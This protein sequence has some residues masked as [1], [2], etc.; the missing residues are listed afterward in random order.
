MYRFAII[1]GGLTA[2]SMVCQLVDIMRTKRKQRRNRLTDVHLDVF[3]K[4][5][6]I[7]PG[8]P[9]HARFVM[10]YHITNMCAEEMTV[11]ISHPGDF[12]S[13]I[14]EN[15]GS[16]QKMCSERALFLP[17]DD[18][19]DASCHHFPRAIMGE[20][21]KDRMNDAVH[22]ADDSG[23]R[24]ALHAGS[25]VVDLVESD[26]RT[27]FVVK[28]ESGSLVRFG[29]YDGALL[30]TGHWTERSRRKNYFSS[31]WPAGELLQKIP[32]G[33]KVGVIGSS[34]SAVEV[35]L[36]LSSDGRFVRQQDGSLAYQ[37]SVS[38]RNITLYSRRGLLPRV[39]GRIGA[40][41]NRYLTCK[42]LRE[43]I[44]A[45]PSGVKLS[46]VFDLLDRELAEVY[47][48]SIDWQHVVNPAK[49][50]L[51]R[52]EDDLSRARNGDG[53]DGELLWQTVLVEIFPVARELYLHLEQSDRARFDHEFNTLF[54]LH[55]AT[56]PAINAE[57]LRALIKAGMVSVVRLGE[58]YRLSPPEENGAYEMVYEQRDGVSCRDVFS[59]CVDARGQRRSV[60]SDPSMLIQN[61]LKKGVVEL[62][63]TT[64]GSSSAESYD[65]NGSRKGGILIDPATHRALPPRSLSSHH[66]TSA[67][68]DFELFAVGA[69][70]RSQIIDASMAYGIARST[71]AIAGQLVRKVQH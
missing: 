35:A 27:L 61:L 29:P 39:R 14:L 21:L 4:Q 58:N 57:K 10:P 2:T 47:G 67:G 70:T 5:N 23:V 60:E 43:E 33:A 9:H 48:R 46:T 3:E 59:H 19:A 8:M 12:M 34:L 13:W 36:T 64:S 18:A 22:G 38:P 6:E 28:D 65:Q 71:A 51:K 54:F 20:Y 56:Q 7:G 11:R 62:V 49:S 25:E 66:D 37:P 40:R 16:I 1:G 52:L 63:R 24:L 41:P 55:A 17:E 32:P 30:A 69:M 50:V 53:A 68:G 15:S 45:N 42:R 31:P 44:E 26:G